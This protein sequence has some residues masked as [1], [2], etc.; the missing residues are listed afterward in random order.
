MPGSKSTSPT[1]ADISTKGYANQEML[2]FFADIN[3]NAPPTEL[4]KEIMT[5]FPSRFG[6]L[7]PDEDPLLSPDYQMADAL[8]PC[9]RVWTERGCDHKAFA[10]SYITKLMGEETQIELEGIL[11]DVNDKDLVGTWEVYPRN[12]WICD[13][14]TVAE[15]DI[16]ETGRLGACDR[17]SV[18]HVLGGETK[19]TQCKM[20]GAA[21]VPHLNGKNPFVKEMLQF[22]D[23]KEDPDKV[24]YYFTCSHN[25]VVRYHLPKDGLTLKHKLMHMAVDSELSHGSFLKNLKHSLAYGCFCFG[26][27]YKEKVAYKDNNE[28]GRTFMLRYNRWNGSITPYYVMV[29]SH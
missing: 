24:V 8:D 1:N 22:W 4:I 21:T 25:G 18:P 14:F 9:N 5:K 28:G 10:E 20:K 2:D 29:N 27:L 6:E 16:N 3:F 11:T 17:C 7:T 15:E 13:K 12:T 19:W 26:V 23:P